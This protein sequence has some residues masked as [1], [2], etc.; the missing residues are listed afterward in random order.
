MTCCGKERRGCKVKWKKR[1]Y[2][3][4]IRIKNCSLQLLSK[5]GLFIPFI[6][7]SR[8]DGLFSFVFYGIHFE[9][10]WYGYFYQS[11][12]KNLGWNVN[13]LIFFLLRNKRNLFWAA[14]WLVLW[15]HTKKGAGSNSSKVITVWSLHVLQMH[16]WDYSTG[17]PQS[18]T[19][20]PPSIF[21]SR[22]MGVAGAKLS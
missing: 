5:A 2:K 19:S 14:R 12:Y 16:E 9:S 6:C 1:L 4:H 22:S 21:I 10:T 15:P 7:Q 13:K 8:Q 18:K 3:K 11:L 17:L 20:I